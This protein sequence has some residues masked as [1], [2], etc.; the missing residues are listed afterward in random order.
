LV[1]GVG[2]G[3]DLNRKQLYENGVQF[4]KNGNANGAA[5][6][7]KKAIESDQNYFEA[8]Y[9]LGLA[10][11]AQ[12]KYESAEKELLKVLKLNPSYEE[13]HIA[14]AKVY[15][16]L[17]KPEEALKEVNLYL[18]KTG[19]NP[20][21]YE[22]AAAA[23]AVRKDY[24]KAEEYLNKSLR[25]FPQRISSK[26][27]LSDIYLSGK[28]ISQSEALIN[29]VLNADSSNKKAL[30][31]L[32]R[33][34]QMQGRTED[35]INVYQKIV[36]T[37]PKEITAQFEQVLTY[38]EI[39]KI[40]SAKA[41]VDRMKKT[42]KE[43]PEIPYLMG[44]ISYYEGKIDDA[45]VFFHESVKKASIPGA[46]YYLGLCNFQKRSWEQAI[47]EFQKV[48][49][50]RPDMVQPHLLLAMTHLQKGRADETEREAKKVL[51]LDE[52]NA[53][54]HNLLGSAYLVMNKGDLAMEEF[55][56][57][58]ELNPAIADAYIKKGA[59]SLLSGDAQKAEK[60]F[61]TAVNVAPDVLSSRI[62]LAKY[63]LRSSRFQDAR[64]ILNE[65][66]KG[67]ANDAFLYNMIGASHLGD[68]D[69]EKA[70]QSFE[71]AVSSNSKF[72][73]PYFNLA[74]LY[75]NKGEMEMAVNEY[76][77]VLDIE[78]TNITAL[79]SLARILEEENKDSES[80]S[81]YTR[82]KE[83]GKPIAYISLAGY[84]Q[85]KNDTG[86]AIQVLKEALNV[87]PR[88]VQ[89]KE[90]LGLLNVADKNY[91]EALSV[92]K[93]LKDNSPEA[94]TAG[95]AKTYVAM[96]DYDNAITELRG[97]SS[98]EPNKREI[99]RE[100]VNLYIRKKDF[101]AAERAAKEIISLRP[102]S[103][104]GYQTLALV[105]TEEKQYQNAINSLKKA[106]EINPKNIETKI[107]MGRIYIASKDFQKAMGIFNEIIRSNPQYAPAYFYQA[108]ILEQSGQKKDAVEKYK[109]VLELSENYVPALNNLAY[110][111]VSGYGAIDKAVDMAK[112]AKQLLPKDGSVTDT[113]GWGLYHMGKY[114]DALQYFI[115]ATYYLP[116]EPTIRYHLGLAYLKKGLE[117]KAEEQLKNS[118]RLGRQSPFPEFEN[119]RKVLGKMKS[120]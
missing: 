97:L 2:C 13:T 88:N 26:I 11:T 56:R 99:R 117:D 64:K 54:A 63:Y 84:Y 119:A 16:G 12:G 73:L 105:Y 48:I 85:R 107:A 4:L 22:V 3:K 61:I 96:G 98:R 9:Q 15:L 37:D 62:V 113:L 120:T 57:A 59:F 7:F 18:N 58:I 78:G 51:T 111:Y 80:L 36:D 71:K 114:D 86:Q 28:K 112:R 89:V 10:Y 45:M 55:D 95:M 17:L 60:E 31:I 25:M 46:Y 94:G 100:I 103:E 49:D 24:E 27:I 47:N 101:I 68:K 92:Y 72:F 53:F 104:S 14:L 82:A 83:Q 74:I 75:L 39:K 76:R 40:E 6:A 29:E 108:N 66:L 67:N 19:D 20:E 41:V 93:D 43:R 106:Q 81:Y 70:R 102:D 8:R 90:M 110:L 52:K 32:A 30:Y 35:V 33:I 77:K 115:E 87:D 65:G 34:R 38:L 69:L 5:V 109:K 79:L 23:Y 21:A 42:N 50:K 116:G 1:I 118:I 44:L 91:K